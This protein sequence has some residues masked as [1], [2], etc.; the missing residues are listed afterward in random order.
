MQ[1][2]THRKILSFVS[3]KIKV[4]TTKKIRAGNNI[5]HNMSQKVK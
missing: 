5:G 2:S 3:S 4:K 1:K